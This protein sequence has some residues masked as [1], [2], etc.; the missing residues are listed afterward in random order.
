MPS[1]HHNLKA[2]SLLFVQ[3][4]LIEGSINSVDLAGAE[5][6]LLAHGRQPM[7]L[8]YEAEMYVYSFNKYSKGDS[9]RVI[10]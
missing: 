1:K 8:W 9:M 2:P 7:E 5:Q 4:D 10:G 6:Q 3:D